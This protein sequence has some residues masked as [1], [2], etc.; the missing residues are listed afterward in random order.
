MLDE[1]L[2]KNDIVKDTL[3]VDKLCEFHDYSKPDTLYVAIAEEKL[4]LSQADVNLLKDKGTVAGW[5]K[6]LSFGKKAKKKEKSQEKEK[7]GANFD[8]KK[9]LVLNEE[10]LKTKY[11]LSK[12]CKPIPGD[13][14]MGYIDDDKHIII[15][16]LDCSHA[17]KLKA[18]HGNRV[19]GAKWEMSRQD[20]FPVSIY[21]KG[22]D[23]L[24]LLHDM[25][26]VI[27]QLHGINIR[28]LEVECDKGIFECTIQ[29]YV[30]DT[31]DVK[32]IVSSLRKIPDVKEATRI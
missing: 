26:E 31:S 25:T 2:K 3:A 30:H 4:K 20:I 27:S 14:V 19:L 32:E 18:N 10:T 23:K 9:I 21:V 22:F 28:K 24:G 29:L 5:K 15:H 17:V 13:A 7:V 6:L 11:T 12:C 16:K 8:K 1:F